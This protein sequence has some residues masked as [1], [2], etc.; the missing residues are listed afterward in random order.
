MRSPEE[1]IEDLKAIKRLGLRGV[2]LPGVPAVE[3]YD[4]PVYAEQREAI[5][6][7]TVAGLYGIDLSALQ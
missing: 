4:S 6:C 3:D 5:L 7:A 2:M 1:G